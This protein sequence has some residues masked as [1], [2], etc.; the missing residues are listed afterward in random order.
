MGSPQYSLT[1]KVEWDNTPN[2]LL[3]KYEHCKV[4]FCGVGLPFNSKFPD[5]TKRVDSSMTTFVTLIVI[6]FMLLA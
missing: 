5:F 1:M 4:V 2:K 6:V 3:G